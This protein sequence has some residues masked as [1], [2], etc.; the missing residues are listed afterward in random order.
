MVMLTI[1]IDHASGAS[2]GMVYVKKIFLFKESTRMKFC[3]LGSGSG[4]NALVVSAGDTH[5]LIDAGLSASQLR[6]RLGKMGLMPEQLHA[7]L[8]THE[9][10]DHCRGLDVLLKKA[11]IPVYTTRL[12]RE[13]LRG[14]LKNEPTWKI[15]T[16]G[17]KFNLGPLEVEGFSIPH[18]AVEPIGFV[19]RGADGVLGILTDAGHVSKSMLKALTG[20]NSLYVEANYDE[21]ML[22]E[23]QKRPWSTKQRISGQHG[24]LSNRQ[25]A[26]LIAE[27]LPG[28]LERVVLGHLSKDCND[29]QV[30]KDATK[31]LELPSD[32]AIH[33]SC[34]DTCT[35]WFP[36]R[37]KPVE[38]P[39]VPVVPMTKVLEPARMA[40]SGY[41]QLAFD[42]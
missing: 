2:Y 34:Q 30:A 18:D 17:S 12:T 32:F 10:Q 33:V 4:G 15:L 37:S 36:V 28:E 39:L 19:L 22:D 24:H 29:P 23:D 40:A 20:V 6:D 1:S 13:S 25:M 7:I 14:Q 3:V 8:L 42:F 9:H 35:E 21:D 26:D 11:P 27:L 31:G 41:T 38:V 16:A 5:V